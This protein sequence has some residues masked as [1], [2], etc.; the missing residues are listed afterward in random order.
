MYHSLSKGAF[1]DFAH[2][3]HHHSEGENPFRILA[4]NIPGGEG[5]GKMETLTIDVDNLDRGFVLSDAWTP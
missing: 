1:L 2:H 3:P 5:P 4:T